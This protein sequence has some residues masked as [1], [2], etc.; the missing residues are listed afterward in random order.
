MFTILQA[1]LEVSMYELAGEL[2]SG[3]WHK[4]GCL[5]SMF[6]FT[7]Q[8]EKTCLFSNEHLILEMSQTVYALFAMVQVRFL[9]RCGRDGESAEKES[10]RYGNGLLSSILGLTIR[11]GDFTS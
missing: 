1:T 4:F 7:H 2:V 9:L 10:V 8:F 5:Q 3:W 11:Y 6:I